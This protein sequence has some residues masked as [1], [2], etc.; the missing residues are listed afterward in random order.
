MPSH[1]CLWNLS[2][3]W[4]WTIKKCVGL[5]C[6]NWSEAEADEKPVNIKA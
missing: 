6:T 3:V 4:D 1:F 5:L 2:L